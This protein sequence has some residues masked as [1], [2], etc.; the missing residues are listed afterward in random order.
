MQKLH[1]MQICEST[2]WTLKYLKKTT[3]EYKPFLVA[4]KIR[5]FDTNA[6]DKT[7]LCRLKAIELKTKLLL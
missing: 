2:K 3:I 1:F 4:N 7:T 5:L 6:K